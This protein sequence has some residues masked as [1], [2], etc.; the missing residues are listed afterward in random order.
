MFP[1]SFKEYLSVFK[2]KTNLPEKFSRYLR[3]SSFP[4]TLNFNG[5]QSQIH[6]YLESVYN[7]VVLKDVIMRRKIA[8]PVRLEKIIRFIFDNIGSETSIL[9]IK[10]QMEND[11]FK[12][13]VQTIENYLSA[14]IDAF[15]VYRAGRYDVKGKSLLKTNDKYYV[16]DIG[17]RY[18]LLNRDE[19]D[20]GHILENIVYLELLRRG[21]AVNIGKVGAKEVDFVAR[22]DSLTEYYQ[23]SQSIVDTAVFNREVEP[24][25]AIKDHK[26]KYILSMDYLNLG[27]KG[28]KQINII[29]WLLGG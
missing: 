7:A 4:Y 21:Y 28:I 11:R 9:N 12:I 8:D 14:L 6:D 2:D 3:E 22:K 13:D 26:P 20:I 17:L 24:L 16:A 5:N 1:L 10:N 19:G 27:Y 25:D 23:V 15:L 18:F 29:D